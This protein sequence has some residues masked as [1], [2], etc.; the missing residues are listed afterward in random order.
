VLVVHVLVVYVFVG[1]LT[2]YRVL[3]TEPAPAT[4]AG[5]L[6]SRLPATVAL[7]NNSW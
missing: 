7:T 5:V 1:R 6:S 4:V 3:N 2:S